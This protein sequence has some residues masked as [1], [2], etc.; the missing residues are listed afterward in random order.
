MSLYT[1]DMH[2][3]SSVSH[4]PQVELSSFI[5]LPQI[6]GKSAADSYV[7]ELKSTISQRAAAVVAS[8]AAT[9]QVG[10]EKIFTIQAMQF[11]EQDGTCLSLV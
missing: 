9:S 2:I 3:D 7:Q 11:G 10:M 1:A 6:L 4:T 5:T 8:G